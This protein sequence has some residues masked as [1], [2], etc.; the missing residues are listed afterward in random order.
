MT[1]PKVTFG[2]DKT[3]TVDAG[4]TVDDVLSLHPEIDAARIV[5]AALVNNEVR[6]L[7][8]HLH[9]NARISPVYLDDPIGQNVYRRSLGFALAIAGHRALPHHRLLVGHSLGNAY[10]YS[11]E[12]DGAFPQLVKALENEMRSLV[13]QDLPISR[14][15]AAYED[16]LSY[17][18]DK[19]MRDAALLV[20]RHNYGEIPVYRCGDF[21]DLSHGPL[22]SRTG[23][24]TSWE[25][26]PFEDGLL[27]VYPPADA[28]M[29]IVPEPRSEMLFGIYREYKE[30]GRVLGVSAVGQLNRI[31]ERDEIKGYIRI[32][33]ALQNKKI[34]AIAD[35]IRGHGA[36][37]KVILIA[38]PSSSGKTTFTKKLAI[39]LQVVG[40]TPVLISLD[41]YFVP[42][43][44]TPR[45]EDGNYDFE[46]LEAIDVALLND[47]LV[48]LF[49]GS[50]VDLPAFNFKTGQREYHG[51]TV[52][53]PERGILLMEGIH[54]LN[55]KLTPR[56]PREQKFK[57]YV[58][59]LTQLNLDDHNRIAT[60]DNRLIRRMVR[61]FKFRGHSAVDTLQMWPSVRRGENRNIFPYQDSADAA[62]NSALDYELSVLR[63]HAEPLLRRV[64]PHDEVFH[65]AVRLQ[66]FL[67]NFSPIPEKHVPSESILREFIGGSGFHY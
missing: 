37:E 33:E 9:I 67:R 41:D 47:H 11:I 65:E 1:R 29:T 22:V 13:E 26:E 52:R 34:G 40:F 8:Y 7:S 30:W 58:S 15:V 17:F 50:E 48:Q 46:R 25:I 53:I 56:I 59:A 18:R 6:P 27:L 19:G 61:D 39:H 42:R 3:A 54:G 38:G 14:G 16:A 62:F 57:V 51:H 12:G 24:L 49:D 36:A 32:N 60:T 21:M 28:P 23:L 43:E 5:V 31:I 45:D 44:H 2:P 4:T 64:K 63:N 10:Y 20:E 55:D 35:Q 66:T